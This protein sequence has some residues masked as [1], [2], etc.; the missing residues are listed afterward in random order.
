MRQVHVVVDGVRRVHISG[1][2]FL[3]VSGLVCHVFD[4]VLD[5]TSV[6]VSPRSLS[7]PVLVELSLQVVHLLGHSL[8]CVALHPRVDGGIDFKP[9]LIEVVFVVCEPFPEIVL[10]RLPEILRLSV[11]CVLDV[12]VQFYGLGLSFL[13]LRQGYHVVP[14][15]VVDDD[16]APLPAVVGVDHGVV[17]GRGLKESDEGGRLLDG[18]F[19]RFCVEVGLGCGLDSV[20]VAAEIHGVEIECEDF[21]LGVHILY[22]VCHIPFLGLHDEGLEHRHLTQESVGVLLEPHLEHVFRQLLCDGAG[23][24]GVTLYDVLDGTKNTLIVNSIVMVEALVL[25]ADERLHDIR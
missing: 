11:E 7:V 15:H 4:E 19:F 5:D 17:H 8:L 23:S 9:V 22:L 13:R 1:L 16:V 25:G 20:C 6:L 12:E 10:D 3:V 21:L 14:V 18:E 2:Q 24:T